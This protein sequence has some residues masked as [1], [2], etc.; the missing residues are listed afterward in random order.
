MGRES[1]LV[2]RSR[3]DGWRYSASTSTRVWVGKAR[4]LCWYT[5]TGSRADTCSRSR[6]RSHP[7]SL[8]SH[9]TCLGTGVVSGRAPRS[10]LL[11]LPPRSPG[12]WTP[13]DFGVRHSSRTRWAVRS[14][15]NSLCAS[16]GAWGRWC[17]SV[18]RSIRSD[19]QPATSCS[20]GCVM[21]RGNRRH[22]SR[23]PHATMPCSAPVRSWR[24]LGLRSPTGSSSACR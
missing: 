20:A 4:P 24:P 22:C 23:S 7:P 16:R 15:P 18:R 21:Q 14:S 5:G 11:T 13:P 6:S 3:A 10:A 9:R 19:A 12:G 2:G 1:V 8:C 17:S